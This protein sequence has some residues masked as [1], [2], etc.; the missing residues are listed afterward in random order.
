MAARTRPARRAASAP[1]RASSLAPAAPVQVGWMIAVG[2]TLLCLA[3][4]ANAF[5][6]GFAL[7]NRQ[8]ILRDPRVHALTRENLSLILNHTYWW[9]YGES[10]LYRPPHDAHLSPQFRGARQRRPSGGLSRVQPAVP[11]GK[12]AARLAADVADHKG[13]VDRS[14]HSRAVGRA[15]AFDRSCHQHRR[16]GGPDGRNRLSLRPSCCI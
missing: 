14:S 10:G 6:A 16:A 5:G 13:P 15:S 4:Y 7:D 12:C 2:L 3:V 9:P 11:R 8:L 1:E